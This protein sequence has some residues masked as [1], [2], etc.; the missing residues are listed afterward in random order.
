MET[1]TLRNGVVM[2][3]I[4]YG[5]YRVDASATPSAWATVWSIPPRRIITRKA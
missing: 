3:Q 5:V 4:G 1:V 2:P